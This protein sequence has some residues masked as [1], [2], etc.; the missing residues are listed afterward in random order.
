MTLAYDFIAFYENYVL[1][2][3]HEICLLTRGSQEKRYRNE[4][5][6]TSMT[7]QKAAVSS[8]TSTTHDDNKILLI[9]IK[10]CYKTNNKVKTIRKS[11]VYRI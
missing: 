6:D 2:S 5:K 8:T 1:R 4:M 9:K 7:R 3:N 10:N 11:R